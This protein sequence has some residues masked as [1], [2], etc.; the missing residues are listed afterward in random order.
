MDRPPLITRGKA[1]FDP[2]LLEGQESIDARTADLMSRLLR[3]PGAI[4]G[5]PPLLS[6]PP[7]VAAGPAL[8][9]RDH[10]H[11]DLRQKGK[12]AR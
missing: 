6:E 1:G 11:A 2:S 12:R 9:K 3:M 5:T 8:K 7:A 10:P 4:R